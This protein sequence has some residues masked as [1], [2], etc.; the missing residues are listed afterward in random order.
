[1]NSLLTESQKGQYRQTPPSDEMVSFSATLHSAGN[2]FGPLPQSETAMPKTEKREKS[3]GID[4]TFLPPFSYPFREIARSRPASPSV[5]SL[6]R[7]ERPDLPAES[8]SPR[9]SELQSGGQK[10][11]R[12]LDCSKRRS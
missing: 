12:R 6:R 9:C 11:P 2:P 1:M 3:D 4:A 8:E 5:P 7:T 10:R